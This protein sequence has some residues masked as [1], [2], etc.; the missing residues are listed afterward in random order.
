MNVK[1]NTGAK[2]SQLEVE[3]RDAATGLPGVA[4]GLVFVFFGLLDIVVSK[5]KRIKQFKL[6]QSRRA[7]E[8]VFL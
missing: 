8:I 5:F 2:K 6:T 3:L 7:A 1:T 4:L